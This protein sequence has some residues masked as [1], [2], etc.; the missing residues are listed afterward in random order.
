MVSVSR[1]A[2]DLGLRELTVDKS[3]NTAYIYLMLRRRKLNQL[4]LIDSWLQSHHMYS[5]RRQRA[6]ASTGDL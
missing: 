1:Q 4:V 3:P 6:L 5:L 2:E